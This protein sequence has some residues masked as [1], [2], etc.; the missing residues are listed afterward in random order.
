[1]TEH[2]NEHQLSDSA[3]AEK[4]IVAEKGML[5][6]K[7]KKTQCPIKISTFSVSSFSSVEGG[8][9]HLYMCIFIPTF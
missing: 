1:M 2:L 3:A 6:I 7:E 5:L 9:I 8:S 4:S